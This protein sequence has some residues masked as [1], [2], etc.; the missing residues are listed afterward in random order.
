MTLKMTLKKIAPFG[1][2][3]GA[4]IGAKPAPFNA[5]ALK[6]NGNGAKLRHSPAPMAQR[7][8]AMPFLTGFRGLRFGGVK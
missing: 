4:P 2:W 8:L 6:G 1:F 5:E 7:S 3:N